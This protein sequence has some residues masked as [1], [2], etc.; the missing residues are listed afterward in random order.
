MK[1]V[2]LEKKMR[3]NDLVA[4]P[5]LREGRILGEKL[6]IIKKIPNK[7]MK[8]LRIN[9]KLRKKFGNF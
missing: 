3:K 1:I 7:F 5:I 6:G 4:L 2:C 8:I 9:K